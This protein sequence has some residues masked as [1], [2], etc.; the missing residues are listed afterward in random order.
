MSFDYDRSPGPALDP[1]PSQII[2]AS[3]PTSPTGYGNHADRDGC[4]RRSFVVDV[5]GCSSDVED[6]LQNFMS[7]SF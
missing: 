1:N 2:G 6:C 7:F 4:L 3:P 5:R